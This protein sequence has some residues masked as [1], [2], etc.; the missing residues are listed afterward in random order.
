MVAGDWVQGPVT[1]A[2]YQQY[3][4]DQHDI[5]VLFI[6]GFMSSML[7]GP[8]VGI[9]A[10][11]FG[12]KKTCQLYGVLYILSCFTKHYSDFQ[13]LA[14][15]RVLG[16]IAT[17]ILMSVFDSWLI[18]S[19]SLPVDSVFDNAVLVNSLVAIA[20][21][22]V[23]D[24]VYNLSGSSYTAVFDVASLF[25]LTGIIV[26][27]FTWTENYG[28]LPSDVGMTITRPIVIIGLIQSLFESTMYCFVFHWTPLVD[29]RLPLGF[30]FCL[31]M[32]ACALGPRIKVLTLRNTLIISALSLFIIPI[33]A[34]EIGLLVGVFM[35]YEMCIGSYFANVA[36]LKCKY[37]DDSHRATVYNLFRVPLNFIV[38]VVLYY[39]LDTFKLGVVNMTVASTLLVYM[40]LR[41]VKQ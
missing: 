5:A 24:V 15:G 1:Y 28:A 26:I 12:R 9:L 6:I 29:G 41:I 37:V 30:V 14:V 10:D 32:I 20:S 16:G 13:T 7:C 25:L 31:M 4:Y 38:L 35:L 18:G 19:S 34:S 39:D 11:K 8:F 21:G 2:L 27:E 22:V 3:G 33:A 36:R 23:A 40:D 17:S